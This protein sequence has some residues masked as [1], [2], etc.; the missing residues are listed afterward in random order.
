MLIDKNGN[1]ISSKSFQNYSHSFSFMHSAFQTAGVTVSP[2][3]AYQHS[4]VYSCIRVLAEAVGQLPVK[5]YSKTEKGRIEAVNHKMF[6][7]LTKMPNDYMTWQEMLELIVTH[8]N[9]DGNFYAY[10]N[11]NRNG[12]IV[13]IIPIPTPSAVSMLMVNGRIT[14]KVSDNTTLSLP[15][16]DFKQDEI[17]HI[18]GASI[19][20]LIGMTPIQNAAR[21]IGLSIA[22][23]QHADTFYQNNATP[24][25]YLTTEATL[26]DE[27]LQRLKDNWNA[28]H[29]GLKNSNKTAVFEEG[30][31]YKPIAISNRDSQFLET[32]EFQKH[33]IC[34]IFRVPPQ[35]IYAKDSSSTY[36]NVEQSSLGFHRDTLVPLITRIVARINA[37]LPDDLEFA[38]DDSHIIKG[39]SKTEAEV[40]DK[41]MKMGIL[42][43]NE[44]REQLGM[45]TIEGGDVH[46]VVTNNITFGRFDELDKVQEPADTETN[47]DTQTEDEPNNNNN[48]ASDE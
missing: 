20:G 47:T 7:V 6:N 42:S 17:L 12:K 1:P 15:K 5:L 37:A 39:D 22:A 24:N 40:L 8:L 11:K 44:I 13:E 36:N 25:G 43:V 21:S 16:R 45:T 38:L 4:T 9:L 32:R 35:M 34:S 14:Y 29:Q 2:L 28:N 46:A 30:M 18:K 19:D 31:E 3:T 10:I 26:S 27:A 41:Y 48:E 33:E 23:E